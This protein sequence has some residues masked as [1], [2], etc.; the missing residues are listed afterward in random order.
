HM[1]GILALR[2]PV[3]YRYPG[4][5]TPWGAPQKRRS[6]LLRGRPPDGPAHFTERLEDTREGGH[7]TLEILTLSLES[8]LLPYGNGNTS[9]LFR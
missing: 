2:K 7:P 3:I 9:N 4:P 1:A 8:N 5:P 6:T